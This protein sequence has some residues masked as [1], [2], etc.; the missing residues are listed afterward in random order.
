MCMFAK[1]KHSGT[2]Q[3][4]AEAGLLVGDGEA[5]ARQPTVEDLSQLRFLNAVF[6]EGAQCM[7]AQTTPTNAWQERKQQ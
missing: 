3:E 2:A 7:P 5:A 6:H 1:L 4:L